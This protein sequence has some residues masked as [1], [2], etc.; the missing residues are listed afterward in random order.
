MAGA[1]ASRKGASQPEPKLPSNFTEIRAIV[2]GDV[3]PGSIVNVMGL[4]KDCQL[5][6]ATSGAG[7]LKSYQS[8]LPV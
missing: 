3:S 6:I 1:G 8:A 4:V 5:P 7:E 2:D